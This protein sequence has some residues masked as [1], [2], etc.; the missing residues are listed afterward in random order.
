MSKIKT[1]T[2]YKYDY[3]LKDINSE[4]FELKGGLYNKTTFDEEGRTL[5]EMKFEGS[6][7]IEQHYEYD[8]NEKGVRTADRSFDE[9]GELV[10]DMEY[11]V[12]HK[13]KTLFAYKKYLDGS[14]D[15]ITY[16]YDEADN[17]IEKELRSDED[18][19]EYV[20][21][22]KFEGNNEILHELWDEENEL[23]YRKETTYNEA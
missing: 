10:D 20:E 21:K 15:T 1:A 19:L 5:S 7:G 2:L 12:D 8:Y 13:G 14:K 16:R 17:L 3:V 6:G 22:F 11:S 23:V 4:E 18:E 9:N